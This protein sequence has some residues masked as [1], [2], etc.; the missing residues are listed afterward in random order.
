MLKHK[1]ILLQLNWEREDRAKTLHYAKENGYGVEIT[2]FSW[3][4]LINDEQN[5]LAKELEVFREELADFTGI[6]T[7]HGPFDGLIPHSMDNDVRALAKK[8][9]CDAINQAKYLGAQKIIFH[10]GINVSGKSPGY[11]ENII[12]K[13]AEFWNEILKETAGIQIC[14]ENMNEK[15]PA[16]FKNIIEAVD[17]NRLKCCIDIGHANVWGEAPVAD[18]ISELGEYAGHFHFSDNFGKWD[19]HLAVGDGA[20]DWDLV[21]KTIAEINSGQTATLEVVTSENNIKSIEY[22]MKLI[23]ENFTL[24]EK[25]EEK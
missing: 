6:K 19:E 18:W 16:I 11:Y 25:L 20:I 5:G 3:P 14:L 15:T 9:F 23:N 24:P 8:R 4:P 22:I 1:N 7:F 13:Q 12:K 21:L 2:S 10:T 17:S